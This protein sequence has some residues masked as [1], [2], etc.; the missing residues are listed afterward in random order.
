[1]NYYVIQGAWKG[2]YWHKNHMGMI[3]AFINILFLINL[4]YSLQSKGKH[5]VLGLLIF[6]FITFCLPNRFCWRLLDHDILTWRVLVALS[7]KIK[8]KIRSSH[9]FI[10]IG[11]NI[12]LISY[13]LTQ[14][15]FLEFL[16]ENTSLTGRIPMWTI[17][18]IPILANDLSGGT[19]SMLFGTLILIGWQCG[20]RQVILTQLL[21]R[22]MVL[23]IY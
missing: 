5:I 4:V 1:M 20:K 2:L 6:I 16:I 3:A 14:I 11:L 21:S 15:I 18:L 8:G 19:A 22:I 13:R 7:I 10:F 23:L 17:Y 12:F 9:Y